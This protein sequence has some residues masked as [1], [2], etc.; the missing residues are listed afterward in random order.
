MY[1]SLPNS[2]KIWTATCCPFSVVIIYNKKMAWIKFNSRQTVQYMYNCTTSKSK[3]AYPRMDAALPRCRYLLEN[4]CL[5][6]RL[7]G[8]GFF[9][10]IRVINVFV[11]YIDGWSSC[12][13]GA[14]TAKQ[15][16]FESILD[17]SLTFWYR[18]L[19]FCTRY[20]SILYQN[21]SNRTS[22]IDSTRFFLL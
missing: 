3:P 7:V 9:L 14:H 15:K 12:D 19:T 18:M 13:Q 20:V 22:R 6:V 11:R 5:R 1:S 8:C 21:V 17:L 10:L 4:V 2:S 16:R